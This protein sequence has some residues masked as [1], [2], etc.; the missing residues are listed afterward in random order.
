MD[1]FNNINTQKRHN[2]QYLD[3]SYK[4]EL[5]ISYQSQPNS[6]MKSEEYIALEQEISKLK[7]ELQTANDEIDNLNLENTSLKKDIR[8]YQ[9]KLKLFKSVGIGSSNSGNLTPV[10]FYS[11]QYRRRFKCTNSLPKTSSRELPISTVSHPITSYEHSN[12]SHFSL[13]S[14][15][16]MNISYDSLVNATDCDLVFFERA[17]RTASSPR[18]ENKIN[19]DMATIVDSPMNGTINISQMA[20]LNQDLNFKINSS[21]L[22]KCECKQE[23]QSTAKHRLFIFADQNGYGIRKLLQNLLGNSF[24][25]TSL[26]KPGAPLREILKTCVTT[27]HDLT[28]SDY[29]LVWGGSNDDNPMELQSVLYYTLNQMKNTNI[30]IGKIYKN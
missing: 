16:N 4:H 15:F 13:K 26:I 1:D 28:F 3:C 21:D 29:V 6:C 30:L 18:S 10:K 12:A 23:E 2:K 27:C 11:P 7:L 22:K 8:D 24:T 5:D 20:L 19:I 14:N 17:Q 25:V 9:H